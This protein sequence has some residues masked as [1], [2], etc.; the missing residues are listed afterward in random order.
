M[1]GIYIE[2]A[3]SVLTSK[4]CESGLVP[5]DLYWPLLAWWWRGRYFDVDNIFGNDG[6]VDGD[7]GD[8][9]DDDDDDTLKLTKTIAMPL[10]YLDFLLSENGF[11]PAGVGEL[12][13]WLFYG[14]DCDDTDD[15]YDYGL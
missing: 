12:A 14:G 13:M 4:W 1:R 11:V 6:N 2:F 8:G 9:D 15:E 5:F 7:G 10:P 3:A